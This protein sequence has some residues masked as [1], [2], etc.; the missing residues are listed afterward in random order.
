MFTLLLFRC[1][2]VP[3]LHFISSKIPKY[4]GCSKI[5]SSYTSNNMEFKNRHQL[6]PKIHEL[7]VEFVY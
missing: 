3:S 2:C 5:T 1:C 4:C 6:C 7:A